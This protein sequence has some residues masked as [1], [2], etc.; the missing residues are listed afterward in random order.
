M[1][2]WPF[3]YH[4]IAGPSCAILT[5]LFQLS[6]IVLQGTKVLEDQEIR[7]SFGLISE[8][9]SQHTSPGITKYTGTLVA[10][11]W[12]D[13]EEGTVFSFLWCIVKSTQSQKEKFETLCH[14]KADLSTTPCRSKFVAGKTCYRRDFDVILLAGL[15][16]LK[17]QVSW[18]ETRTV[19]VYCSTSIYLPHPCA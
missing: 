4:F 6:P 7:H 1:C 16:E 19:R 10:P 5:W 3:Y 15:T 18:I 14:V 12:E 2:S 8:D 17:A 13:I 11:K 9:S